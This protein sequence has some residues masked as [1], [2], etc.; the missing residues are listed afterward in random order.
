MTLLQTPVKLPSSPP[1]KLDYG[2]RILSLGS[3]FSQ[4]IGETLERVGHRIEINPF[5]ILYNPLSVLTALERLSLQQPYTEAELIEHDGLYHSLDHH[6]KYSTVDPERTLSQINTAYFRAAKVLP[7][8]KYLLLTWGTAFVYRLSSDGRVVGNC[9]KLPE[10]N[11]ERNLLSVDELVVPWQRWLDRFLPHHPN[12]HII[13]S[14]SPIRHLRDGAHGNQLSKATLMLMTQRLQQL[15]PDRL[16][17]FPAYEIVQD[18]LRDYRF[19]TE[20]MLHP[21]S[22]TIGIIANR[23]MSWL[24]N[25]ATLEAMTHL[26]RLRAEYEHRPLHHDHPEAELRR[27]QLFVRLRAFAR[28]YPRAELSTWFHD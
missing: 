1:D 23:F 25:E 27:E 7:D 5:G 6:G 3:C 12:L 19:Y 8:M 10:R 26:A 20:D 16:H 2:D 22:Q 9:H 18:E 11:F 17:Y 14:I 13:V 15:Y 4:L 28:Q 21:S 24:C